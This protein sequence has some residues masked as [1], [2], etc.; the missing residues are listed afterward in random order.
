MLGIAIGIVYVLFGLFCALSGFKVWQPYKN[1]ARKRIH[2]D[3]YQFY[4]RYGGILI[5]LY[6]VLKLAMQLN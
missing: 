6:G 1:D 4:Y 2:I 3:K 5:A